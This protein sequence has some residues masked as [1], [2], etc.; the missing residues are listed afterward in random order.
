MVEFV[1]AVSLG[2]F[3]GCAIIGT[4]VTLAPGPAPTSS[5]RVNPTPEEQ[6]KRAEDYLGYVLRQR[7]RP[8]FRLN[9]RKESLLVW[10]MRVGMARKARDEAL[11][12]V[13]QAQA[14]RESSEA[15]APTEAPASVD[16]PA[17]SGVPAG[18]APAGEVPASSHK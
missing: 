10:Q 16:V 9:G 7:P 15:S 17:S 6:L 5:L 4:L 3:I 11:A 18:D 2:A 14:E 8:S 12:K 1:K 13:Q